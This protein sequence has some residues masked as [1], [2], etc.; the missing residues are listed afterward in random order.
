MSWDDF[1]N[2]HNQPHHEC[3]ECG[4]PIEWEGYCCASCEAS[5]DR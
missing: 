2:P 4:M 3:E 5:R 1:M